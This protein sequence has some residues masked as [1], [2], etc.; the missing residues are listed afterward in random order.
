M[1]DFPETNSQGALRATGLA[2]YSQVLSKHWLG[3]SLRLGDGSD[4]KVLAE[5]V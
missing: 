2:A 1:K 5:Q 3:P 4:G